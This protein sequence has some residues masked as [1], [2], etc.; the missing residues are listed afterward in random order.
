MGDYDLHKSIVG[1]IE[2]RSCLTT[3]NYST[4]DLARIYRYGN[5]LLPTLSVSTRYLLGV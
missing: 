5:G 4:R 1:W 3:I 2:H